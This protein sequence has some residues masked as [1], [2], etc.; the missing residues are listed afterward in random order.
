MQW[1]FLTGAD[2]PTTNN[3]TAVV[4][5]KGTMYKP[6]V[7][8]NAQIVKFS[9]SSAYIKN[10]RTMVPMRGVFD[11]VNAQMTWDNGRQ[12]VTAISGGNMVELYIGKSTAYKNGKAIK[13]EA[14]PEIYKGRTMVPL[15]FAVESLGL[16]VTWDADNYIVNLTK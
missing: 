12:K 11:L 7:S 9:D 15:R 6:L 10:K 3:T 14:P 16:K 5:Q 13:L 4:A 2:T 8:F 1:R